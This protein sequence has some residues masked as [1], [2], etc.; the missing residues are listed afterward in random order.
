MVHGTALSVS[1]GDGPYPHALPF[2]EAALEAVR[3]AGDASLT[4]R[5]ERELERVAGWTYRLEELFYEDSS[6]T[7]L[8]PSLCFLLEREERAKR[9]QEKEAELRRLQQRQ[10]AVLDR[11]DAYLD[12]AFFEDAGSLRG[13]AKLVERGHEARRLGEVAARVDQELQLLRREEE[14]SQANLAKQQQKKKEEAR[15]RRAAERAKLKAKIG[16]FSVLKFL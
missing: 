3:R 7:P 1:V 4:R 15:T 2:V 12:R 6:D 10:Q 11:M 8:P 16:S 5:C 13:E 9:I 14:A